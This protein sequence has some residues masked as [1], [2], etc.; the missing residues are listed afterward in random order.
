MRCD[1]HGEC[2]ID[3]VILTFN[4]ERNLGRCLSALPKRNARVTIIDSGSTDNTVQIA[5]QYGAN[6]LYRRF[7]NHADQFNWGLDQ[8][9]GR[10]GWVLRL[11]ADEE[12]TPE[13]RSFI[14]SDVENLED[15][16]V[17]V[18]V[19]MRIMFLGRWLRFGGLYGIRLVRMWRF[20]FGR[21]EERLMD[22]HV[23]L[24]EGS[25]VD[26]PGDFL[27]WTHVSLRDWVAKHVSYA[28]REAQQNS[29]SRSS[30]REP[31]LRQA[32]AKR[33]IKNGLYY[34]MPRFVRCWLFWAARYFFLGG[35]LDGVPGF[36][37]H[38]VQGLFYRTLVD[39]FILGEELGFPCSFPNSLAVVEK[40]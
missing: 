26:A 7:T 6:V 12:L 29:S 36:V 11:D 32:R 24:S 17:G 38:L 27:H 37:Y 19:G 5:T 1:A 34:R 14:E 8:L 13:L 23:I 40:D 15:S 25:I 21:F 22:E 39:L 35:F 18:S 3:I 31:S 16:V 9:D 30:E 28:V 10:C 33:R 4:E 2:L 20:G